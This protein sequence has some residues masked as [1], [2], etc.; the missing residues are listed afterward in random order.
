MLEFFL[1]EYH[2]LTHLRCTSD[3][4]RPQ[5]TLFALLSADDSHENILPKLIELSLR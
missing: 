2:M 4:L 1:R 3:K 5:F